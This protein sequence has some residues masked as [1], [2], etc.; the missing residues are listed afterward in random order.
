[1]IL[2]DSHV[3]WVRLAADVQSGP[4]EHLGLETRVDIE[5]YTDVLDMICDDSI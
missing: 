1:V 3:L 4:K 2:Q 5:H